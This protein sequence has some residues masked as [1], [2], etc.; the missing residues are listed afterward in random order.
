MDGVSKDADGPAADGHAAY[1]H[2]QISARP[3]HV[4]SFPRGRRGP[5]A[6]EECSAMVG[7]LALASG[8]LP[9]NR[10]SVIGLE[11]VG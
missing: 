7:G 2:G 8:P 4:R 6:G 1:V 10:S 3:T 11:T 9:D 5:Q